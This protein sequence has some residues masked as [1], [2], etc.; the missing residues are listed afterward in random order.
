MLEEPAR[1]VGSNALA[2]ACAP[3]KRKRATRW[4]KCRAAFEAARTAL[5]AED[6]D[7]S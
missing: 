7:G 1:R 3:R 4:I 6:R 5:H 2:C